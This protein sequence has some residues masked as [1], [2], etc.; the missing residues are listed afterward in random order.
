MKRLK[1]FHGGGIVNKHFVVWSFYQNQTRRPFVTA[2]MA[3]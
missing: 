1:E 2:A 3:L